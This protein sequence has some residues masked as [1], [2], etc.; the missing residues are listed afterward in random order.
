[1]K[2]YSKRLVETTWEANA[3]SREAGSTLLVRARTWQ[4]SSAPARSTANSFPIFYTR[5]LSF[6]S[7]SF[8]CVCVEKEPRD[9]AEHHQPESRRRACQIKACR[10]SHRA[11]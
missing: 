9:V 3:D 6:F 1:M 11:L 8:S 4:P 7:V 5:S 10:L 2:A